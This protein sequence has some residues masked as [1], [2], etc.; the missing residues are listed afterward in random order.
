MNRLATARA[1]LL[2][3][4]RMGVSQGGALAT[5]YGLAGVAV[6]LFVRNEPAWGVGLLVSLA[7]FIPG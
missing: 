1:K 4:T 5:G 3:V 2:L 7:G 6:L